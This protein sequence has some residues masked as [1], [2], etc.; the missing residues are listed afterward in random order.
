M[1]GKIILNI[2]FS[3]FLVAMQLSFVSGLPSVFSNVNLVLVSL[4]F[5][6]AVGDL[7][8]SI[9]WVAGTG[10]LM[11]VFSFLPFGTYLLSLAAIALL[12]DLFL[13]RLFTNRSLY[14]FLAL[15][16][17]ATVSCSLFVKS[18]S[19]LMHFFSRDGYLLILSRKFFMNELDQLV[20][21]LILVA[22]IFYFFNILSIKL[23]PVF[24]MKGGRLHK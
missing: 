13:K 24:L 14:T 1:Y 16:A 11:D 20:L 6:L 19:Y 3:I 8:F 10:L 15:T 21:N 12:I 5:I 9:W 23:K 7:K 4:I 17:I 18:A 22:V 2:F